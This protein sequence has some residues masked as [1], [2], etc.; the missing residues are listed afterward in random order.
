MQK[1]F[2][3]MP[4][5]FLV[6]I[7]F[8]AY[9]FLVMGSQNYWHD[10][11]IGSYLART[12]FTIKYG[13]FQEVP[14]WNYGYDYVLF[15]LYPPFFF[16]A[17]A[18]AFFLFSAFGFQSVYIAFSAAFLAAYF[19]SFIAVWKIS[20]K[21]LPVFLL[22]FGN[23]FCMGLLVLIGFI[24]KLF[25]FAICFPAMVFL[26]E[27]RKNL[28]LGKK[29][30]ALIGVLLAVLFAA[31]LLFFI[32]FSIFYASLVL[33]QKKIKWKCFASFALIPLL[34]LPFF[35]SFVSNIGGA[36]G[37]QIG[38]QAF[39][40]FGV[41]F[42][43]L[44]FLLFLAVCIIAREKWMVPLAAITA[45]LVFN[46][47]EAIPV[48]EK[49]EAAVT[50]LFLT[51]IIAYFLVNYDFG[52]KISF[53][54]K[55]RISVSRQNLLAVLALFF[56]FWNF[57][58]FAQRIE[59]VNLFNNPDYRELLSNGELESVFAVVDAEQEDRFIGAFV[60]Y[61]TFTFGNYSVNDWEYYEARPAGFQADEQSL[62]DS[63]KQNNCSEFFAVLEKMQVKTLA[64][65]NLPEGFGCGTLAGKKLGAFT[66][67]SI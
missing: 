43:T 59:Q 44:I 20:E 11:D 33:A 37:R 42:Y 64:V 32:L 14:N 45:L 53:L 19:F 52:E 66:V 47:N 25:A 48:L 23:F 3:L 67:F 30:I 17:A 55:I 15:R 36:L 8:L 6:L 12:G 39:L 63:I 24:T 28:D 56:V 18:A 65:K 54:S 9:F 34:T 4:A 2:F 61:Q 35:I 13:A 62:I 57:F 46:L 50:A 60:S 58:Y 51:G 16:L 38:T 49:F 26:L 5:C 31:H 27:K 1:R 7:A 29:E 10:M 21:N 40:S 22:V 41:N